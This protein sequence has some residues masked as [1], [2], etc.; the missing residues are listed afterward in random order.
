MYFLKNKPFVNIGCCLLQ[1]VGDVDR[2][3]PWITVLAPCWKFRIPIR[4]AH[5]NRDDE[6]LENYSHSFVRPLV[7]KRVAV[8][9]HWSSKINK[10]R[11]RANWT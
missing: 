2:A 5:S 11:T 9:T 10:P 3:W 6:R 8:S 7:N 4:Q 1:F